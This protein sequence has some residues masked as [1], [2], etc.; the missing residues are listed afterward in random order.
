MKLVNADEPKTDT[1][2]ARPIISDRGAL[3]LNKTSS[4]LVGPAT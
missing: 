3:L 4:G 2:V 1:A